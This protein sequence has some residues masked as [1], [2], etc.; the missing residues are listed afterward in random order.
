M[1]VDEKRKIIEDLWCP[2]LSGLCEI[3]TKD[4]T[5]LVAVQWEN[6]DIKNALIA[7]KEDG[8]RVVVKLDNIKKIIG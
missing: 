5:F 7:E 8:S 4:D 1:T 3:I 2:E 6:P